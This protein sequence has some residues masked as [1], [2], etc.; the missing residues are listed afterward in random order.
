MRYNE[1]KIRISVLGVTTMPNYFN[2]SRIHCRIS[3]C[4]KMVQMTKYR[5]RFLTIIGKQSGKLG[6]Q[7]SVG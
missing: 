1:D 4:G 5:T 7:G 3:R 6:Q 2:S